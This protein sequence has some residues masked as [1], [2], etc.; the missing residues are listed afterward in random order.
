MTRDA[1]TPG[2]AGAAAEARGDDDDERNQLQ[3]H[4]YDDF[5]DL[6]DTT[7]DDSLDFGLRGIS[8]PKTLQF[9]IPSTTYNNPLSSSSDDNPSKHNP[10]SNRNGPTHI[11]AP[12]GGKGTVLATPARLASRRIVEDLLFTA[13]LARGNGVGGKG[14]EETSTLEGGA[15]GVGGSWELRFREEAG[16]YG[17]EDD[18]DDVRREEERQDGGEGEGE[19]E[20]VEAEEEEG[21]MTANETGLL[22]GMGHLRFRGEGDETP[23]RG[24]FGDEEDGFNDGG[25]AMDDEDDNDDGYG[26]MESPSVVRVARGGFGGRADDVF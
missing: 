26:E 2:G 19:E 23:V 10:S 17:E 8:P 20:Y 25:S 5:N 3:D 11:P 12:G 16:G 9:H 22:R 1:R 7:D 15:Y 24:G 13:G 14:G 4:T 18:V 6:D 21:A